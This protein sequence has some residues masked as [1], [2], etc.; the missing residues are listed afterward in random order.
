[1]VGIFHGYVSHN[2]DGICIYGQ[3]IIIH[4]EM[5]GPFGMIPTF[6]HHDSRARAQWGRDQIWPDLIR[7]MYIYHA[8]P[9]STSSCN[10]WGKW[11]IWP[12]NFAQQEHSEVLWGSNC[13]SHSKSFSS[14]TR[15]SLGFFITSTYSRWSRALGNDPVRWRWPRWPCRLGR[16]CRRQA[17]SYPLVN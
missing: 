9:I 13:F 10:S 12:M 2:Q 16:I 6:F 5:L 4:P 15:A 17:I 11:P 8:N 7:F 14:F 3:I 1:M